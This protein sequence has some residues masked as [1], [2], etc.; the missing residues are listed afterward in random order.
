MYLATHVKYPILLL[1]FNQ[2]W[3]FSTDCRKSPHY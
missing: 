1:N 3:I 2:T